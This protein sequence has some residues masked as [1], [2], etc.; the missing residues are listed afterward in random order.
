MAQQNQFLPT[1][2]TAV[3]AASAV[4][5]PPILSIPSPS[6]RLMDKNTHTHHHHHQQEGGQEETHQSTSHLPPVSPWLETFDIPECGDGEGEMLEG[7]TDEE[8]G[9]G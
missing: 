8:S 1:V 9:Q 6:E 5:W 4:A 2:A 3:V 7:K